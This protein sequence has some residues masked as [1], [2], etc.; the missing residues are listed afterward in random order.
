MKFQGNAFCGFACGIKAW[1]DFYKLTS[2]TEK[3]YFSIIRHK[4]GWVWMAS[5]SRLN[6]FP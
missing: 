3:D 6:T 2:V 1:E 4:E 5:G